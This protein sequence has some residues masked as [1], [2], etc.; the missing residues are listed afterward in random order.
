MALYGLLLYNIYR[1]ALYTAIVLLYCVAV[2]WYVKKGHSPVG[3]IF[4]LGL[5]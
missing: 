3:A 2:L 1:P 4:V 5:M